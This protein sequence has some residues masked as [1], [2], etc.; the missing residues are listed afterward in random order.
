MGLNINDESGWLFENPKDNIVHDI[1]E[2]E[3]EQVLQLG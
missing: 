2:S 1:D 3:I